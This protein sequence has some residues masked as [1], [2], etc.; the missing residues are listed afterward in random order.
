MNFQVQ[1]ANQLN[2]RLQLPLLAGVALRNFYSAYGQTVVTK[3]KKEAPR[4][5]GD[6]RG[7]I[8]FQHVRGV[9]GMPL[10]IDVFSRSKYALFVHGFL[11]MRVNMKKPWT[12]SRLAPPI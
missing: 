4:F 12:R 9:G 5:T 8:T 3:A 10:G 2:K 7:S 11:D 6:L 1:G